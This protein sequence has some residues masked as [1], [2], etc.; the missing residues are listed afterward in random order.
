MTISGIR[1]LIKTALLLGQNFPES[2]K[3]KVSGVDE[4]VAII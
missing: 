3:K 1:G 2:M 4:R